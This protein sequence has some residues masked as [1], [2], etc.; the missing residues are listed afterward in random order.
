MCAK[1]GGVRQ[2]GVLMNCKVL[3]F[4]ALWLQKIIGKVVRKVGKNLEY[5]TEE[6][7]P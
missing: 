2:H 3:R 5:F 1:N 7:R 4:Q 6:F